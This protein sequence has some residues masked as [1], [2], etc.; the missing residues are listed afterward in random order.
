MTYFI[1]LLFLVGCLSIGALGGYWTGTSVRTWY[2]DLRKPSWNPPSWV[3]APMW[4]LLYL[5]MGTSGWIVWRHEA[6]DTLAGALFLAQLALNLSWSWFFFLKRR[7]DL[8]FAE[9]LLLWLAIAV[10]LVAFWRVDPFAGALLLPYLAWVTFASALNGAVARLNP[11]P[12][13][14]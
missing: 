12:S 13:R 6:F 10:T 9:V 2:V 1:L 4:T 3:F 7:P 5:L 11:N 14:A 8:A